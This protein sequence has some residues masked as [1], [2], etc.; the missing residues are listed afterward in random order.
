[1]PFKMHRFDNKIICGKKG[2][3][4]FLNATRPN[5][6][7]KVCPPNTLP[8]SNSTSLENTLCYDQTQ[9]R[10]S[11]CPIT[12]FEF[13]SSGLN[14]T[15]PNARKLNFTN[16]VTFSFSKDYDALPASKIKVES[17]PCADPTIQLQ[18]STYILELQKDKVC[19]LE[20]NL[21]SRESPSYK[22]AGNGWSTN[23][24]KV[25]QDNRVGPILTTEPHYVL[26]YMNAFAETAAV[27]RPW[28]RP[29]FG[30]KLECENDKS[31]TRAEGFK[32]IFQKIFSS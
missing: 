28:S 10:D 14:S 32:N 4:S 6:D 16:N 23:E 26:T 9:P 3:P 18:A 7:S 31:Q 17:Q 22:V 5:F 11:V 12:K 25:Q 24:F 1:M 15:L 19:P 8:C 30:W 27:L 21:N 20:P 13:Y 2:G 29:T